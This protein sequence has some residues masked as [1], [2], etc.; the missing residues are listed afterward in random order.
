MNATLIECRVIHRLKFLTQHNGHQ[1]GECPLHDEIGLD[2]HL[3]APAQS[4]Q[5][6]LEG[7]AYFSLG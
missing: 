4:I 3:C 5:Y 1:P 7:M 6:A 2:V